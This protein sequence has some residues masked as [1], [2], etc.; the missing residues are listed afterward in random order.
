MYSAKFTAGRAL[1]C[2]RGGY[3]SICHSELRDITADMLSEVCHG[4]G[5]ESCLE[6]LSDEHM[7]HKTAKS[8]EA[9]AQIH[10]NTSLTQCYQQKEMKKRREFDERLREIKHGSSLPLCSQHLVA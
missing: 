7:R 5:I 4:V 6:P 2:L 10:C 9:F 1:N 3:P 8:D